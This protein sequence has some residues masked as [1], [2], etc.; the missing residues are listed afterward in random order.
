[1]NI[2]SVNIGCPKK[3]ATILLVRVM[4]FGTEDKTCQLYYEL[5]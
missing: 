3:P 5:K 2:E 4:P 1:M